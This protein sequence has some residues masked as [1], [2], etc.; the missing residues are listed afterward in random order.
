MPANVDP[1]RQRKLLDV[2]AAD[3]AITA[4][5]HRRSS[6]PELAVITAADVSLAELR[7]A[8]VVARTEVGDLDRAGRKL[9]TEIEQVRSRSRRD[10]ERLTAGGVP[11]KELENLQKEIESLSRRQ[12]V[13]EDEALELMEKQETADAGLALVQGNIASVEE[14]GSAAKVRRD[15]A[16]ADIDDELARL[17][18]TRQVATAELP[19]DLLALYERIHRNGEIAAAPLIGNQCGACRMAIDNVAMTS[20][21]TAPVDQVVRC[22]ECGAILI[23]G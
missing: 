22:P 20:L 10:A 8:L 9:D 21:R 6:L 19:A 1:V 14:D 17:R 12:G 7:N 2:A 13:L 5:E 23:R 11:A 4:A 18:Q 15:D 16:F 3:R